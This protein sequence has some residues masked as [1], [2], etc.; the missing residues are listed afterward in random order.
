MRQTK[1]LLL[2]GSG[3]TNEELHSSE[4]PVSEIERAGYNMKKNFTKDYKGMQTATDLQ[5]LTWLFDFPKLH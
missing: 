1:H 5:V 3:M 2:D 4:K